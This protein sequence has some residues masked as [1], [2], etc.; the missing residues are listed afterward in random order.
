LARRTPGEYYIS[1]NDL[2]QEII[3]F[4]NDGCISNELGKMLLT[5][6]RKYSTK[7]NFYGY[8]WR[9]DMVS[10]AVCTCIRYLR[11]FNPEKSTNA[12]AYVTQIFKNAFTLVINENNRHGMI[13]D[14]CH[15]GF[16]TYQEEN[17]FDGYG[18]QGLDYE[19]VLDYVTEETVKNGLYIDSEGEDENTISI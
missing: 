13:K 11:N 5:I 14:K 19:N 6:A 1:N 16:E 10:E 2:L 4:K 7:S 8:T 15:R 9:E 3:R 12:F 17:G 18:Q